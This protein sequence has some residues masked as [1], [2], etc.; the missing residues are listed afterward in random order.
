MT[1]ISC[2]RFSVSTHIKTLAIVLSDNVFGHLF[3]RLL[4][5]GKKQ[6]K[7]A[8]NV[9][10]PCFKPIRVK[11]FFKISVNNSLVSCVLGIIFLQITLWQC[12]RCLYSLY[13]S[14]LCFWRSGDDSD[15][16]YLAPEKIEAHSL[17]SKF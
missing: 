2:V 12:F 3:L 11:Y 10:N 14:Y 4:G 6:A 17:L 1:Q 7:K 9:L 15:L 5:S 16:L 13:L 8:S